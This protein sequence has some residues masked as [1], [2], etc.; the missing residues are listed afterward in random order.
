[1]K[2][3][4]AY[5]VLHFSIL[6]FGSAGIFAKLI[7]YS[8]VTIVSGRIFFAFLSLLIY[9]LLKKDLVRINPK[10]LFY[11]ILSGS[12]LAFHWF[13]F[14][15]AIKVLNVSAGL[16][17]FSTYP[18]FTSIIDWI[19]CKNKLNKIF[20]IALVLNLW[21]IYCISL[22]FPIDYEFNLGYLWGVLSGLSF[23]ILSFINRH[24]VSKFTANTVS[25]YQF[26]F[27][28]IW[29]LPFNL[30]LLPIVFCFKYLILLVIL[31]VIFT[32]LSHT[33]FIHSF[34]S[35]NLKTASLISSLE[36][37][38]GIIIAGFVLGFEF[39]L[40]LLCGALLIISSTILETLRNVLEKGIK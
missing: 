12:V 23:A 4:N 33:L 31:G 6:L 39:N 14:F 22:K 16:L 7:P 15:Q 35:I 37:V 20:I 32:A 5:L 28:L 8:S 9:A 21:G 34:K 18:I 10:E 13:A 24:L 26:G 29:I 27:A 11:F 19:I 25:L 36:P 40:Y 1:M 17:L 2:N 38:Y 3:K 30:A